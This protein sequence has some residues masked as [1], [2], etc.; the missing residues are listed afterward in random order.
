M[1]PR[2]MAPATRPL[3]I[4]WQPWMKKTSSPAMS[5]WCGCAQAWMTTSR[6]NSW[7]KIQFGDDSTSAQ[8]WN[9]TNT[10]TESKIK[11]HMRASKNL[12]KAHLGHLSGKHAMHNTPW[13][14]SWNPNIKLTLCRKHLPR[15]ALKN[16]PIENNASGVQGTCPATLPEN[17]N[18]YNR[19]KQSC[20]NTCMAYVCLWAD[21]TVRLDEKRWEA[22]GMSRAERLH[23]STLKSHPS[24]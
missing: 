20:V 22:R 18:T 8:F 23:G 4:M 12:L 21:A 15:L 1:W 16:T 9:A 17:N 13:S 10:W 11:P 7:N 2:Q 19:A 3:Y 6:E 14:K 5:L 24:K